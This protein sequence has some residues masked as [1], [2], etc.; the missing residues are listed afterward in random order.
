MNFLKMICWLKN[1]PAAT[2]P[3]SYAFCCRGLGTVHKISPIAYSNPSCTGISL[4]LVVFLSLIRYCR[5]G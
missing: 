1:V 3:L 2:Q 5:F 4:F